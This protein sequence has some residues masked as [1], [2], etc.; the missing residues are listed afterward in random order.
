MGEELMA[1][2]GAEAG[3]GEGRQQPE[4]GGQH[5]RG[6][7][8]DGEC[9]VQQHNHVVLRQVVGENMKALEV[10]EEKAMVREEK[11]KG[12]VSNNRII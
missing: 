5:R 8:G 10:E 12:Q 6:A 2:L 1:G 4:Q 9:P 11:V 7:E 3:R